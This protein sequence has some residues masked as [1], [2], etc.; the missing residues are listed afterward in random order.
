MKEIYIYR[1]PAINRDPRFVFYILACC[2]F[3]IVKFYII[4][5][6][7]HST[8]RKLPITTLI[9]YST[10]NA[11][12]GFGLRFFGIGRTGIGMIALVHL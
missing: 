1:Y 9:A 7:L 12:S 11:R 4:L 10:N 5:M 3:L 6:T 8:T 2:E